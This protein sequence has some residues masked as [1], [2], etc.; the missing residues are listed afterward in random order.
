[1]PLAPVCLILQLRA[2][3]LLLSGMCVLH[4]K[5]MGSFAM[6]HRFWQLSMSA[7]AAGMSHF[8]HHL[9]TR[10]LLYW[11]QDVIVEQIDHSKPM[12]IKAMTQISRGIDFARFHNTA[13]VSDL[14]DLDETVRGASACAKGPPFAYR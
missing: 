9:N 7:T 14:D 6:Q 3:V 12:S 10:Y 1:M 2:W 13:A 4:V 8:T 11:C 5:T